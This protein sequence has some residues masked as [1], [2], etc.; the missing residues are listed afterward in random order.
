MADVVPYTARQLGFDLHG[1]QVVLYV[2]AFDP[3]RTGPGPGPVGM[4]AGRRDITD[5]EIIVDKVFARKNGLRLGDTLTINGQDLK[6]AGISSGGDVVVFQYGFVTSA[7]GRTLLEAEDDRQRLPAP[8][9][10]RGVRRGRGGGR[11]SH[12]PRSRG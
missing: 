12:R 2:V 9:R 4:A 5:D 1:R 11:G 6:V 8:L 7:R 10:A 3:A